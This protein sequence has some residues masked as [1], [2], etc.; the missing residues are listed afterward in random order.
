MTNEYAPVATNQRY[1]NGAAPHGAPEDEPTPAIQPARSLAR[2][3]VPALVVMTALF[4]L[5]RRTRE[6]A[7]G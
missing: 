5:Q 4:V 1:T 2:F 3:I 7:A 6:I